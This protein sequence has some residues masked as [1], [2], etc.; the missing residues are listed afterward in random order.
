M[1]AAPGTRHC[2]SHSAPA[3]AVSLLAVTESASTS[4]EGAITSMIAGTSQMKETERE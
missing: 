1:P 2:P 4:T 3:M